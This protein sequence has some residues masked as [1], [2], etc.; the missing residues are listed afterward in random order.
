MG[1]Q[2]TWDHGE[3]E[4]TEEGPRCQTATGGSQSG[5]EG[6][7][8]LATPLARIA[9]QGRKGSTSCESSN[10]ISQLTKYYGLAHKS[11]RA[12]L[13]GVLNSR[14]CDQKQAGSGDRSGE[15][16]PAGQGLPLGLAGSQAA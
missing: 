4:T 2:Q 3:E 12:N 14:S 10:L 1:V 7:P 5:E 16:A 13:P 8:R 11:Q 6:Q 9:G 15:V